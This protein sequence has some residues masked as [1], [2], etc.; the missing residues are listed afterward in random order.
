MYFIHCK[1]DYDDAIF[2]MVNWCP[3]CRDKMVTPNLI[4]NAMKA[5][6]NI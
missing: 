2:L 5:G 1:K 6:G 4:V 3:W